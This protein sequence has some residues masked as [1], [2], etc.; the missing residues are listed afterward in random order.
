MAGLEQQGVRLLL[1]DPF[2]QIELLHHPL[3]V[4][5]GRGAQADLLAARHPFTLALPD[6]LALDR[7][8]LHA[9]FEIVAGAQRHRQGEHG[10]RGGNRGKQ[11]GEQL[12][13]VKP[14]DEKIKHAGAQKS[15]LI[16]LR[17]TRTPISIQVA[18]A[19][20]IMRPHG[21]VHRSEM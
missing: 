4:V 21:C 20:S 5:F 15:K 17:M 18:Q 2:G 1:A 6:L 11:H 8:A 13:V 10:R 7:H 19:A 3:H 12:G 9:P 14:V 16:I